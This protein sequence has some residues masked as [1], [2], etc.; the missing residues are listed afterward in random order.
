MFAFSLA[1]ASALPHVAAAL[2]A[3]LPQAID[4]ART[5]VL[6]M[7]YQDDIIGIFEPATMKGYL[8]RVGSVIDKAHKAGSPVVLVKIGF[9]EGY[10]EISPNNKNGQMIKSFGLFVDDKL[11]D[12]F[13]VRPGDTVLT[14]HRA[15]AFAGTGLDEKLKQMGVDTLIMAGI[16]TTGVVMSSLSDASDLDYRILVLEDGCFDPDPLAH[17]KLFEVPFATRADAIT[18]AQAVD[19]L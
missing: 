5:A 17:R 18:A 2:E 3:K 15:S 6:V 4:P 9:S 14:A 7:H 19:M 1:Y 8:D 12:A 11:P 13:D 16:T 10:P